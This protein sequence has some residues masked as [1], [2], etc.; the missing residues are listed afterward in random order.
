MRLFGSLSRGDAR[1][2]SDAD[3]LIVVG[4]SNRPF[5]QRTEEYSGDW[6]GVGIGC[7][8]LV[9]TRDELERLLEEGNAFVRR[10]LEE[11]VVLARR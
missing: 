6:V 11:G 3:L 7:D 2:G 10:A 8:I 4:E 5:L 1:P 9:Y